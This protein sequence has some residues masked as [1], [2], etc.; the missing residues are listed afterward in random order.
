L[1]LGEQI[2]A[3]L[4]TIP[5]GKV[6]DV[7]TGTGAFIDTLMSVSSCDSF[8]G[9]D[10]NG[11]RLESA[12]QRFEGERVEFLEMD[13]KAIEF[14]DHSFDVVCTRD[15]LHVFDDPERVLAEMVRVLKPGGF[16]LMEEPYYGGNHTATL[17]ATLQYYRW[18]ARVNA[19]LGKTS[20]ELLTKQRMMGI[21]EN[22]GLETIEA[23]ESE[24][25]IKHLQ[26]EEKEQ[27][28]EA[29]V[30]ESVGFIL[31]SIDQYLDVMAARSESNQELDLRVEGVELKKK[32]KAHGFS[33]ALYLIIVGQK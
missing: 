22:L 19:A 17:E 24:Y 14:E 21:V 5:D 15:S 16:L 28:L 2:L 18:S 12:R 23:Y 10:V 29:I 30:E 32:I 20:R 11:D 26:R 9:I 3:K 6:L 33:N 27:V 31:E 13:A 8:V 7:G 25:S 4:K 1:D